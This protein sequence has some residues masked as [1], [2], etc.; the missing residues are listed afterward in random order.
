VQDTTLF[1][2]ILGISTPW[3]VARV[4]LKTE[5]KR[6]ELW[7][8]HE[9][10]RWPCPECGAVLAGSTT[11]RSGPGAIWTRASLKRTCMRRFRGCSVRRM[12]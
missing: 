2:T 5:E 10:T 6:V 12:A 4:D 9:A 1:E 7:L 3:Y 11:L 8:A